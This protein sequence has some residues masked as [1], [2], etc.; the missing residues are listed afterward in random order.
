MKQYQL[1]PNLPPKIKNCLT[2]GSKLVSTVDVQLTSVCRSLTSGP[3]CIPSGNSF[4]TG[5]SSFCE[6]QL[7][8][9]RFSRHR[10]G[11][12]VLRICSSALVETNLVRVVLSI[13]CLWHDVAS[14]R[15][16]RRPQPCC[17]KGSDL[18]CAR[19]R[20]RGSLHGHMAARTMN[21]YELQEFF[22]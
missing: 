8:Q 14:A 1:P 10:C 19:R 6:T 4:R 12:T 20:H 18:C 11:S 22:C 15:K 17:R 2:G 3:T 21:L 13:R 9:L 16:N 7:L 5:A